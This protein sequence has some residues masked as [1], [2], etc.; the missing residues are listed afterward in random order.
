MKKVV[1]FGAGASY[2]AGGI[3]PARPPLG[4]QLFGELARSYPGSWGN[5]PAD[6]RR[7]F[8][9]DFEQGMELLWDKH[10]HI[11]AELTQQMAIYFA[12]FRASRKG[13]T[14]YHYFAREIKQ[15]GVAKDLVISTLNYECV[16][17]FA[18]SDE[19]LPI[20]YFDST[21]SNQEICVWKLHGSCNFL[22]QG[23][24]AGRG[25]SFMRGVVFDTGIR[26]VPDMNEVI[27]YCF[28]D[29]AIPPVM[30]LYMKDK[31]LQV[32][33]TAVQEL[34]QRW[35]EQVA[36][37]DV[38]AVVGVNP[39]PG[40]V[41]LWQALAQTQARLVY[42]GNQKTFETWSTENH[43]QKSTRFLASRFDEGFEGLIAELE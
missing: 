1:L 24:S 15:R 16:L 33:Q 9:K 6:I 3:L 23:M 14:L 4:S 34:Q 41:H 43:K 20:N 30:C 10:S 18:L 35:R 25:V 26:A 7:L 2:G 32:A 38:I 27:A 11:V 19:G 31:P 5:F 13:S 28:S 37:A 22:P 12:Q 39:N 42:I 36:S 29:N 17:E 40:D 21:S 8:E